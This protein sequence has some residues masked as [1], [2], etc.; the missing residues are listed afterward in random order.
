MAYAQLLENSVS[1]L[2]AKGLSVDDSRRTGV[3]RTRTFV[4]QR[5]LYDH[6]MSQV[7]VRIQSTRSPAGHE[8][9]DS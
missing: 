2:Y 7:E 6:H 8:S 5:A 3:M 4:S 9:R 1:D